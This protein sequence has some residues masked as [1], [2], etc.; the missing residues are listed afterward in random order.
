MRLDPIDLVREVHGHVGPY[1][2]TGLLAAELAVERVGARKHFGVEAV[3]F[4]PDAPPPSCFIDGVQL[5]SGCTMGKRNIR[6][7][8]ADH[9]AL[10]L[11]NRDTGACVRVDVRSEIIERAVEALHAHD[12]VAGAQV[13]LD[14]QGEDL[15][16]VAECEWDG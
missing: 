13:I 1:V 5:G 4:A 11:R 15:F 2:V 10:V 14:A 7:A 9:V 16:T 6:H 8:L 3:V 12:D